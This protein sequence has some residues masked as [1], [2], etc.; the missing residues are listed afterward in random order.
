MA[1]ALDRQGGGRVTQ[2]TV[3]RE[4]DFAALASR[5][6]DLETR[7]N[8]SFF[9]SW[10]WVGCLAAERFTAPVLVEAR[11]GDT[12]V[13][14]ALFN[15]HGNTLH[16]AESGEPA[17]DR[18]YVEWNGILCTAGREA[19]LTAACL[20]A[21]GGPVLVL[22]GIDSLTLDA[23]RRA[24]PLVRVARTQSAPYAD[25]A[26]LRRSGTGYLDSRSANTRAQLRR[27]ARA[28]GSL[29]PLTLSRAETLEAALDALDAMAPLH[30]ATWQA[31]D[32]TGCFAVPFFRRFH[33][34]LIATGLPRGEIDLLRVT[35]GGRIVGILYNFCYRG[36]VLAYQSGFDYRWGGNR[37][38]PGLTCHH[39]AI[40]RAVAAGRDRY[41][42]LAG[43]SRYKTSLAS[44]TE[45]LYW[46]EAGGWLCPRLVLRSV[47]DWLRPAR[48]EAGL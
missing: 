4:V 3:S 15:R 34:A 42:F 24:Y 28:F 25:L 5:W 18:I 48:H 6:R 37:F 14:L 16:L 46:A 36:R 47:R 30:Q 1:C 11:D 7:S 8:G 21:A 32:A 26:A 20:R 10:T 13:A 12:T 40:E 23:A 19:E 17:L 45:A 39:L 27:S 35:A 2:I 22:N 38:K 33:V 9:Q 41:D 44:G 43:E 29:G 31:R